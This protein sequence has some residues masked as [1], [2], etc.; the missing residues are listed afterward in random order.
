LV[1]ACTDTEE[2]D[3]FHDEA[4]AAHDSTVEDSLQDLPLHNV[5]VVEEDNPWEAAGHE[6]VNNT[7]RDEELMVEV[8][9]SMVQVLEEVGTLVS[10][11][12][13]ALPLPST[14]HH[15]HYHNLVVDRHKKN[16][17]MEE[18]QVDTVVHGTIQHLHDCQSYHVR[19][20]QVNLWVV[21]NRHQKSHQ[22]WHVIEQEYCRHR[23]NDIHRVG[24]IQRHLN[25]SVVVPNQLAK[26]PMHYQLNL[27]IDWV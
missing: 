1:R 17:V 5:V 13:V 21:Q 19:L 7:D 9:G 8:V 6:D 18:L 26:E 10:T 23:E 12:L 16:L 4:E 2:G 14:I 25:S 3:A 15:C 20:R 24:M 11:V 27:A 22:A